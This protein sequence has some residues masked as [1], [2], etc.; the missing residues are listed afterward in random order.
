[1]GTLQLHSLVWCVESLRP[2]GA[3]YLL[4]AQ[5]WDGADSMFGKRWQ[6]QDDYKEA[7]DLAYTALELDCMWGKAR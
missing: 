2:S 1:M 3:A 7:E 5:H 4:V 6:L